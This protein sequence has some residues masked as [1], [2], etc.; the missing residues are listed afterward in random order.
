MSNPRRLPILL[1]ILLISCG[2]GADVDP[3][4]ADSEDWANQSRTAMVE[5]Q[6]RAR[7]IADTRVLEAMSSVPRHCFVP[8]AVKKEAYDDRPL[9]I[10]N[11][12]TISQPYIVAF[13]TQALR[14]QPSDRVL[15]IGTGSG[16]QAAVLAQIASEVY[17]IEILE[18]L[19]RSAKALFAKLDY[20]N[21]HTRIGDGALGWPDQAPFDAIILT[22]A[23]PRVPELLAD[24]LKEGGRMI[25]PVGE[26]YQELMLIEKTEEGTK[27]TRLIPVRFVPMTGRIQEGK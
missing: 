3:Q 12:Q 8:E 7:G 21:I 6:I 4:Q 18:P 5:N 25:L 27:Q 10:G 2:G 9:P 24:Q 13:M 17:T 23:P 16:Y 14:L 20:A 26:W 11:E 1:S 22:A 15:E 19:G